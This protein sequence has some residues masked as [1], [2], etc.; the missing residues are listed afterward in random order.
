MDKQ[1][2]LNKLFNKISKKVGFYW[3]KRYFSCSWWKNIETPINLTLT[4]FS[5]IISAQA[6]TNNFMKQEHY[7]IISFV[8]VLLTTFN[9]YFRPLQKY[10]SNTDELKKWYELGNELEKIYFS[11]RVS[12]EDLIKRIKESE[13]LLVKVNNLT[14]SSTIENQN[15]I[16]DFFH[17]IIKYT[18][19]KHREP[20]LAFATEDDEDETRAGT[21]EP[22][23]KEKSGWWCCFKRPLK[24][25]M[26]N[27]DIELKSINVK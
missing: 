13:E 23:D 2:K 22:V 4:I 27:E 8:M 1:E 9:T 17:M 5:S 7:V 20:W 18:C 6:S 21:R 25:N 24:S 16:S 26:K 3:W 12:D 19:L 10:Q 11:D 15:F 14:A